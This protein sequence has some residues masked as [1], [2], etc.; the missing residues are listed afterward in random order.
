MLTPTCHPA[1]SDM[2]LSGFTRRLHP[3]LCLC[4]RSASLKNSKMVLE[5]RLC[6]AGHVLVLSHGAE[7]LTEVF[8]DRREPL[9]TQHR[10]FEYR[11]H[12]CATKALDFKRAL[13]YSI[14]S[15][16]EIL[17]P[18]TFLRLHEELVQDCRHPSLSIHFS[19][20]NRFSPGALSLI[21][22]EVS[23]DSILVYTF[24]TFP[25]QLAVVKTQS[26]FEL[27]ESA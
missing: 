1:V 25:N 19:S 13:H 15:S 10:L 24:H 7:S 21:Q 14:S 18:T 27:N 16:L 5:A 12:G 3:E 23:R 9:P 17:S 26:L 2:L 22:T 11:P 6:S 20:T 8:S 4:L